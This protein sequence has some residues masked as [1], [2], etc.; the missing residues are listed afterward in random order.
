MKASPERIWDVMTNIPSWSETIQGIERIEIIIVPENNNNNNTA[1]T[2]DD[3]ARIKFA[4]PL[5]WNETRTMMGKSETQ[6][7]ELTHVDHDSYT[8]TI[9]NESCGARMEFV[10]RIT[11]TPAVIKASTTTT[12]SGDSEL[13]T[14]HV[15]VNTEYLT[16]TSWMFSWMAY[17]MQGFMKKVMLQDLEDVKAAVE[18]M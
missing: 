2:D 1:A 9:A 8:Y 10:H 18:T 6:R 5:S 15:C 7:M 13:S 4:P 16:W 12:E 11:T 17:L 14:V 3:D